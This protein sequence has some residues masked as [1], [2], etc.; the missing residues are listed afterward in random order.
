MEELNEKQNQEILS[1]VE[2]KFKSKFGKVA[3]V[4]I[5]AAVS[6]SLVVGNYFVEASFD[7]KKLEAENEILFV[8]YEDGVVF[9]DGGLLRFAKEEDSG[10]KNNLSLIEENIGKDPYLFKVDSGRF[11]GNFALS[12]AKVNFI[13]DRIVIMPDASA[14]DVSFDG[15]KLDIANYDGDT[16]VGILP[17]DFEFKNYVDWYSPIFVNRLLV[18]RDSKISVSVDKIDDR[19][20]K[21]LYSKL[22]KEFK[23]SIIPQVEKE[24]PWTFGNLNK[25]KKFIEKSKQEVISEIRKAGSSIA[26][27]DSGFISWVTENLTLIPA[28]KK[29]LIFNKFSTRLSDAL[30]YSS[31]ND[32]EKAK[33][34]LDAFDL[35]LKTLSPDVISSPIFSKIVAEFFRKTR[36]F[37]LD[38]KQYG[39]YKALLDER[40]LNGENQYKAIGDMWKGVYKGL[41]VGD[42][43]AKMAFDSYY[44]KLDKVLGNKGNLD[45]YQPFVVYQNQLFDN[46]FMKYPVFYKDEYF[47]VK[48]VLEKELLSLYGDGQLK[49][50]LEQDLISDKIDFLKRLVKFFFDGK[51]AV[52]DAKKIVSSLF[53]QVNALMPA[54]SSDVAVIAVFESQLK[55]LGNFWGYLNTPEYSNSTAYGPTHKERYSAYVEDKN[56]IWDIMSLK[57]DVLGGENVKAK[58]VEEVESEVLAAFAEVK[59]VSDLKIG[60]IQ[61]SKE[62]YVSVDGIAGGYAFTASYDREKVILKDVVAYGETLSD[63]PVKIDNLLPVLKSKFANFTPEAEPKN[64]KQ[65]EESYAQR[66]A[67]TYVSKEVAKAGFVVGLEN[68]SMVDEVSAIYRVSDVILEG[69]AE[70]KVTFDFV[71]NG[72][73]A[74]NVYLLINKNSLVMEGEYTLEEL[75]QVVIAEKDFTGKIER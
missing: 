17:K 65:R 16:Y 11:W 22:I 45:F 68:I 21:L 69:Y 31:E 60:K 48:S 67:R 54:E 74:K 12:D 3:K 14:I 51:V 58:S 19:T 9:S 64:D 27:S 5:L 33:S 75:A 55:D 2:F 52:A 42:V 62:R 8:N 47:T 56:K 29:D 30:Y 46:L 13:I 26:V 49:T 32:V 39:I 37:T 10:I 28:K 59:D 40:F 73:K 20:A 35:Y 72:E 53:S 15:K 57:A 63:K 61:D 6:L 18:P 36:V 71:A 24:D 41:N 44:D 38:D 25:D 23:Y 7:S 4:I 1:G 66:F 34:S 50:E 70:V 43:Y